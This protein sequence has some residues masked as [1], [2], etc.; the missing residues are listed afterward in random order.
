MTTE[1]ELRTIMQTGFAKIK[2]KFYQN[3][4]IEERDEDNLPHVLTMRDIVESLPPSTQIIEVTGPSEHKSL[5]NGKGFLF[6]YDFDNLKSNNIEFCGTVEYTHPEVLATL[7][8]EKFK[9]DKND[10]KDYA[11][12]LCSD[13]NI[14][15]MWSPPNPWYLQFIPDD[16]TKN[17]EVFYHQLS[18]IFLDIPNDILYEKFKRTTYPDYNKDFNLQPDPILSPEELLKS[19]TVGVF[20]LTT[21]K[22]QASIADIQFIPAVPDNVKRTFKRAKDLFIFGYFKYEFFT[23]SQHYAFL[24]LEAAIKARYAAS[25]NEVALLTDKKKTELKHEIQNPAYYRI[26]EF[27]RNGRKLGWNKYSL[28]VNG[29][30]FPFNGKELIKWLTDK[31][32]IR[33]WDADR[34]NAGL[35]LRNIL[36]HLEEVSIHMP[37]ARTLQN[38]ANQI[39][40]LFLSLQNDKK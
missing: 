14:T 31:H 34:Y 30:P 35:Q 38:V 7:I 36:S 37:S 15:G 3:N 39:N 6:K 22:I 40:Y 18:L 19:E 8:V 24:A 16:I 4:K 23:I 33:K 5:K 28:L 2:E 17:P 20:N 12:S 1:S 25:L 10:L 26:E 9:I 13:F 32:I 21:H 11:E 27:I 29:E